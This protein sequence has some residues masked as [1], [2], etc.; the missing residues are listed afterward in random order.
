MKNLFCITVT[1]PED[2]VEEYYAEGGISGMLSSASPLI[3]HVESNT[4]EEAEEFVKENLLVEHGYDEDLQAFFGINSL[5]V[6][7]IIK[8]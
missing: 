7:N 6:T 5:K 4:Q 3:F 2:Y 1:D 8:L